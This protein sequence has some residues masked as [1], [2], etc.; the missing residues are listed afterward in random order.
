MVAGGEK[1]QERERKGKEQTP[2]DSEEVIHGGKREKTRPRESHMGRG[3]SRKDRTERRLG[4]R[5]DVSMQSSGVGERLGV[6]CSPRETAG[7]NW[8]LK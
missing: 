1:Q 7:T 3:K 6:S 5:R 2:K 8:V 4:V